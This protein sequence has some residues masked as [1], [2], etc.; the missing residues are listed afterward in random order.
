[1]KNRILDEACNRAT[2][3]TYE[4]GNYPEGMHEQVMGFL[5]QG[6]S[7]MA[8]EAK[9]DRVVGLRFAYLTNR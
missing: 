7:L 4:K 6:V 1:M 5:I 2:G 3:C 9:T 8:V